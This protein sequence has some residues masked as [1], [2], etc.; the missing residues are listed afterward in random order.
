MLLSEAQRLIETGRFAAAARSA[1]TLLTDRPQLTEGWLLLALAEQRQQRFDAMLAAL[2]AALR[3][4]PT[5]TAVLL[6]FRE[7]QLYCGFGAEA[8]TGLAALERGAQNDARLLTEIGNLYLAAGAHADRLRC[9]LRALELN[10]AER[11]LLANA[12][13]AE[14]ACGMIAEAESHLDQLLAAHP[15]AFGAYYRRSTLRRQTAA[16][17][18]VR[19]LG[20]RLAELPVDAAGIVP[21]CF[22]L[23]KECE[24][25]GDHR[26]AAAYLQ[27]GAAR[28][29]RNLSYDVANDEHALRQIAANFPAER[30][31]PGATGERGA[32]AIFVMG[33]PRS[34]T[35]LVDRILSSHS[36]VQSL[37]EIN[38][39]AYAVIGQVY[40]TLAADAA[41]PER[42][43]LIQRSALLDHTALGDDYLR[44]VAGYERNRPRFIDKTP[45]N[46]LYLG[47]IALALPGARIV[48]VRRNP[49]D[50]CFA[51]YKT[52][53]R[54]G[55]PYSYDLQDLAR[56]YLAYH[57]LMEHWRRVLPGRFLDLDY[58]RVVASQQQATH[59][60]LDW[61]GLP[62]EPQCLE[63]HRNPTPAATASAAQV[64]EP[65]H[66]RS[67][68][69]WRHYAELLEPLAAAL[70][71]GGVAV[72][73]G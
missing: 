62:Y 50:S 66:A 36:A 32:A 20:V 6:K 38:D 23:A 10:P 15:D 28:R 37:G 7:A 25:L 73:G 68:G 19:E 55:S 41:P 72:G 26:Q 70:A 8:R 30:F 49:M 33:L 42:T 27:R 63:F 40:A 45:W 34:G 12:A 48:H 1:R 22:A 35:T 61:C 60:L 43:E 58:E 56:Y 71:A 17:N 65:L 69:N 46:F 44:R 11:H 24:D 18:H 31:A 57:R 16:A 3:L 51:L 67:V 54:D 47:L 14:T 29:R 9:A 39:L 2:H 59:E 64:R 21:L 13:A 5:N 53:F 4:Q 52:L